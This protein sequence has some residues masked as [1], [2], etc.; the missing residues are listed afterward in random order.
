MCGNIQREG[1]VGVAREQLNTRRLYTVQTAIDSV[2][3]ILNKDNYYIYLLCLSY[4]N[5]INK[6][7]F[8]SITI[9]KKVLF[10]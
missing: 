2:K 10:N 1:L 9:Y 4:L 6:I 3:D 5:Y 8:K 7:I